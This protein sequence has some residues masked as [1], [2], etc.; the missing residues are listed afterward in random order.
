[1]INI[2]Y[3]Q[4]WIHQNQANIPQNCIFTTLTEGQLYRVFQKQTFDMYGSALGISKIK[5]LTKDKYEE[6]IFKNIKPDFSKNILGIHSFS[7]N[8]GLLL[9]DF[10]KYDEIN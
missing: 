1:M 3:L 5:Y 7:F 6:E 9:N 2:G 8:S 4:I 10:A